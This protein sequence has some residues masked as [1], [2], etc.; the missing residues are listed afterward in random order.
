MSEIDQIRARLET[1]YESDMFIGRLC[2]YHIS[3]Q[4]FVDHQEFCRI[5]LATPL[6]YLLP[7]FPRASDVFKRACTKAKRLRV[8]TDNP[9]VFKNYMFREV[10][11]DP[12]N[13]WRILVVETVDTHGH[14]LD[15]QE[16]A[17]L[18]FER[19]TEKINV[20]WK[21]K[22]DTSSCE[23]GITEEVKER[24]RQTDKTLHPFALR[25]LMRRFLNGLSSTS[26]QRGVYFIQEKHAE[27]IEA[28]DVV[29]N[30]L[31]GPTSFHSVPLLD[32]SRQREMLKKA[33][34]DEK[35]GQIDSLL[36]NMAKLIKNGTKITS[37]SYADYKVEADQL[38]IIAREYE[39]LLDTAMS[40]TQA[41]L[42]ILDSQ[43][44]TLMGHIKQ[45]K[46]K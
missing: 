30:S 19:E 12:D 10:G 2:W 6:N 20:T 26:V 1:S 28:L 7:T 38:R 17:T 11:K 14:K 34:E 43:L 16:T 39:E 29:F 9:D 3:E 4:T 37:S 18:H 45:G 15:Y 23:Y 31:P 44:F 33:F 35:V 46:K 24:F 13:I 8:G 27:K 21:E 22:F 36:G 41:R 40:S 32:D 25:Q 42:D 5:I